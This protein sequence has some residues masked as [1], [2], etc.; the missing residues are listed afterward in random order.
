MRTSRTA[1]YAL[2][3]EDQGDGFDLLF[4]VAPT[5]PAAWARLALQDRATDLAAF[6]LLTHQTPE[7]YRSL[8]RMQR[9]EFTRLASRRSS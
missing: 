4:N 6:C 3:D 1:L 8:T 2:F 9:N 7:V 5:T